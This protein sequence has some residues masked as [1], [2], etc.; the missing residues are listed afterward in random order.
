VPKRLCTFAWNANASCVGT[1]S[2]ILASMQL[3]CDP[4]LLEFGSR[5]HPTAP[6]VDNIIWYGSGNNWCGHVHC[7]G[8][9][10]RPVAH[11]S[12]A[13]GPYLGFGFV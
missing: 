6:L 5:L 8:Q 13:H 3:K 12:H 7:G 1:R 2:S 11:P 10:M 9:L 4:W